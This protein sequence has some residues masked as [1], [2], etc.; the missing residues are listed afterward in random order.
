MPLLPVRGRRILVRKPHNAISAV[1]NAQLESRKISDRSKRKKKA[2]ARSG[3]F[4]GGRRPFGYDYIPAV[5]TNQGQVL[6]PGRLV[7][8]E[9]EALAIREAAARITGGAS[10]RSVALWLNDQGLLTTLGNRWTPFNLKRLLL[11]KTL[12][13]IR[14][15]T[16]LDPQTHQPATKQYPGT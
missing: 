15:H 5:R 14:E 9:R 3:L 11:S 4:G 16:T 1:N 10:V 12:L 6:E 13:G 7:P 2:M 8:N